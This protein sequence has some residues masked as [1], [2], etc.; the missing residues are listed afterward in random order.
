MM[1]ALYAQPSRCQHLNVCR[2]QCAACLRNEVAAGTSTSGGH[3][4]GRFRQ[5]KCCGAA[6][7]L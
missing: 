4:Q 2:V 6:G 7:L 1:M 5:L 3:P